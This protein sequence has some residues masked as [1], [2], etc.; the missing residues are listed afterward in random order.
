MQ[1]HPM[2]GA[3]HIP[4]AVP[5]HPPP[6]REYGYPQHHPQQYYHHPPQSPIQ[7]GYYYPHP[8]PA[9]YRWQ[10]PPYPQPHAYPP[11]HIQAQ[12][13][14]RSPMVVS[15][16]PLAQPM[17]PV[18]RQPAQM[19][20]P[21][22]AT[23][24]PRPIPPYMHQQAPA[25]SPSPAP[26]PSAPPKAEEPRAQT[27][28]ETSTAQP[29]RRPSTSQNP[30]SLP[31]EHKQPFWPKLPWYSVPE[32]QQTFPSRAPTRRRRRRNLRASNNAVA[33]PTREEPVAEDE[34]QQTESQTASAA[35]PPSETSTI[36]AP[37]EP[38]TPATSQ[39]PSESDFT[40]VST[41]ATPAQAPTTSP[42]PTP[43]QQQ[44]ARRDTR[45]AIAVPNIPGLP[46]PKEASPPATVK[47][48]A[49]AK[50]EE[51]KT[52]KAAEEQ[53]GSGETAPTEAE[54]VQETP[55]PKPA[56]KSW[57]DLVRTKSKPGA[58]AATT[59]GEA[60]TNGI[61]LPKT[62]SLADALKQYNVRGD[63]MLPFL[64]P[65]GLVN[66]GN[67]CY[68]NSILQVLVFC[69]PFYNFLDQV[70]QRT[71]HSMKSD[72]PLVDA[73][74]MF[75]RE[76]KV[77]ASAESA[78]GLRSML[79]QEQLEEYGEQVTPEYV[80]EVIRK[81]PR[82]AGMRRGQQ[83]DAEEFLGFLLEGLHDECVK[84][85]QGQSDD[86]PQENGI[87]SPDTVMSPTSADGWQEV[88]PKQKAAVTRTAGQEDTPSPITKIFGGYLRSEF[89]VPGLKD[90]VTLEPYKPLQLDI[91]SAQVNNIIDALKGLT[92]TEQMTGEF[93]G[94]SNS[95]KKQ[96]FI[97]SLPPVLIL[98]L[99][100]FQY[101]SSFTGTQ[102]IWKKVGYPLELEIPKEV[103]PPGKRN[104]LG[105]KNQPKYRLTSVV[106]HHGKSAA[107]GH[108]TVDVLRQDSREWIRMDDTIIR[109]VRAE[110][111]AEGGAE[112]DPKILAK[113]LEQH[114]ADS[115]LQKQR[116]MY[117][118]LDEAEKEPEEEKPWSEVN[119]STNGHAKK[120]SGAAIT[121]N[122]T[123]TP[124]STTGKRTPTAKKEGV[125]DNKVAYILLY[126]Q[127]RE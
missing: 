48:D 59:N 16:A 104:G 121:T 9:A 58:A 68:M 3:G 115:D 71:V 22:Q 18:T 126:E 79:K 81:L 92:R 33:L 2:A 72:T 30:L 28:G 80:Y 124:T 43:T 101:D 8:P 19:T 63:M 67:M 74:I 6:R 11:P 86:K 46:K 40:Q 108:Y 103:F 99:K 56:P 95:A 120:W 65:K 35:E 107:G 97:D 117:Q 27:P 88:G 14:P 76:F 98:H 83:Q 93:G 32:H 23:Q 87:A 84:V 85:M 12:Y 57:A 10:P 75:M 4:A 41:P 50:T 110:D 49:A 15:S 45:T 60:I 112:E 89:R 13:Q 125:R 123:S 24:S 44:H 73:M 47:P 69:V 109:R 122:G 26:T 127:I 34:P 78:D 100:R 5:M 36:A 118:G 25:A 66:T 37:S 31:P 116:N 111:V 64:E 21:P 52:P 62:A 38:E 55:A 54:T 70:R 102:K 53:D 61:Q 91:G 119:G 90:S 114:K 77:L 113:A 20:A 17:T 42:K 106:Y 51:E 82:F 7:P 1:Q 29:A 96:M 39:A 94:R 105:V